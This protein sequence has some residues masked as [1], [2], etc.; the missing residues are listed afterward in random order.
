MRPRL[1]LVHGAATTSAVWAP[2]AA[3]LHDVDVVAPDRPSSGDLDTELAFLAPLADGAVVVGVS[4]GATLG[5]ALAASEVALAGAVLHEPAVGSLVPDLLDHVVAG[6][7]AAGIE[8]FGRALYGPGWSPAMA[9]ADARAVARDLAMFRAFE[10]RPVARHQGPVVVTVGGDSPPGRHA[11]ATALAA[12]GTTARVL[13]G[14]RHF[15]QHDAPAT[16]AGVVRDVVRS[17]AGR[18]RGPEDGGRRVGR[19]AS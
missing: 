14:C 2:L 15:V 13:P 7:A 3:L 6:Y 12:F 8:G 1:L 18:T 16:F 19:G 5:L 11:A 17:T 10:P 4:G 9:P